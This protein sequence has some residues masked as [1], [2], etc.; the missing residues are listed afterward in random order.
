[1]KQRGAI[2]KGD[3]GVTGEVLGGGSFKATVAGVT[4]GFALHKKRVAGRVGG[5]DSS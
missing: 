4:V 1:M 3:E 5:D 2:K